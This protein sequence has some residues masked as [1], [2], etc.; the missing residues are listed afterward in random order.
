M[1]KLKTIVFWGACWGMV[2]ATL[3]WFLHLVH[4]KNELLV[5][6]PFGLMCML[7]A[8]KQ[9]GQASAVVKTA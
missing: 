6:Y 7:M 9:T 3:G 4:L 5:L 8:A 1:D 2:E